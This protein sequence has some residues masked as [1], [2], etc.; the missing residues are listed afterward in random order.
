M[1]NMTESAKSGP[2]HTLIVFYSIT[3]GPFLQ[4]IFWLDLNAPEGVPPQREALIAATED[5]LVPSLLLVQSCR[6]NQQ[7]R[8]NVTAI[9]GFPF[10]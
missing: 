3:E 4:N 5:G 2:T 9:N 10:Q 8:N 7:Q 6:L 1:R